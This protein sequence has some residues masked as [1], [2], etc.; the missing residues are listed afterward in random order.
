[1]S[2]FTKYNEVVDYL[3][4]VVQAIPGLENVT[5][6]RGTNNQTNVR[7]SLNITRNGNIEGEYEGNVG[8]LWTFR[9]NLGLDVL[10]EEE[11]TFLTKLDLITTQINN[12]GYDVCGIQKMFV[13]EASWEEELKQYIRGVLVV[14]SWGYADPI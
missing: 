2:Y 12:Y 11:E 9:I 4:T 7:P 5:I 13:V 1:M 3:I 10:W 6:S 14:E 8:Y